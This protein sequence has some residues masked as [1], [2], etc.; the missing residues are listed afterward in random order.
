MTFH[1]K[2]YDIASDACKRLHCECIP[3]R[4]GCVLEGR[5]ALSDELERRIQELDRKREERRQ[6]D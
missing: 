6:E 2:H 3:G 1:C 5:V 4:R